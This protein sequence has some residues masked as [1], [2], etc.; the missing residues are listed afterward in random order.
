MSASQINVYYRK[1]EKSLKD[2][3]FDDK[4]DDL[5]EEGNNLMKLVENELHQIKFQKYLDECFLPLIIEESEE[6]D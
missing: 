5:L 2:N 4:C 1:V 3:S 6:I